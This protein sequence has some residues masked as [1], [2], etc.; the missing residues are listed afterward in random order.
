MKKI[1]EFPGVAFARSWMRQEKLAAVMV[2]VPKSAHPSLIEASAW[3]RS[4]G[5]A[6]RTATEA[7]DCF[8]FVQ[9]EVSD[10]VL[11]EAT[12]VS[13]TGTGEAIVARALVAPEAEAGEKDWRSFFDS[14]KVRFADFHL[15]A[16]AVSN[17]EADKRSGFKL[18]GSGDPAEDEKKPKLYEVA[19]SSENEIERWF[20][21]EILGHAKGEI[22]ETRV[23][24]GAAVLV[25]HYGDQVGVVEPGTFRVDDDK[26]SRAYVRFSRSQ[27]GQE[28]EQ[29][30]ADQTRQ[31]ISV[32]YFV[33]DARLVETREIGQD[34]SGRAITVDVWRVT[35]WQ[36]AE[37][38]I[39]SVPADVS[40]GVGRSAGASRGTAGVEPVAKEQIMKKKVRGDGGAIIEVDA[41]DPRP[42]IEERSVEIDAGAREREMAAITELGE[43]QGY[44]L[45]T[46]RGWLE[47]RKTVAEVQTL[48]LNAKRTTP[49][50]MPGSET[51]DG[52]SAKD[53]KRYSY[54]RAILQAA[55]A[56]EGTGKFDGVEAEF[57]EEIVGKLDPRIQRHDGIFVPMD[58]R[59]QEDRWRA[60]EARQMQT[61]TLES[62]TP[63]KG[64]E[65]IF[66]E[67]GELIEILRQTSVLARLGARILT[68]LSAPVAFPKQTGRMTA[69]WMGEN[70]ATGVTA[71][72]LGFGVVNLAPKTIQATTAFSRQWLAQ[73]GFDGE[74]IVRAE[75]GEEHALL[76]DR[77]GIHGK[78][79][80]GEPT[81]IY[82]APDAN[83]RAVGGVPDLADAI[84]SIGLVADDNALAGTLGWVTTPLMAAKL[85]QIL[86]F[87]AAGSKPIWDGS[88]SE[89]QMGGYRALSSN[90][91][92]KTM[93]GSAETGGSEHGAIFGNWRELLIG[94]FLGMEIIVDPYASKTKGLIEVTS[95]QMADV[96][97]RHGESFCKWTGATIV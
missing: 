21:L 17:A 81:G 76:W 84:D 16:R 33:N 49:V 70:P 44:D 11:E 68:G 47:S 65:L 61:R 64:G 85:R 96:V 87:S 82:L 36:P 28:I 51:I 91:V 24:R 45:K 69:F 31:N 74:G 37:V 50:A 48:I 46:V 56:R 12:I 14:E 19:V 20:G 95:F 78:G 13:L 97:L 39:V 62:K 80:A 35:R 77:S 34:S 60:L 71:S 83:A 22:D 92:S 90:Q 25:D 29:D 8:R 41:S 43:S 73:S 27:R 5:F 58:L 32:G 52:P 59:S 54:A 3:A 89:G 86:E 18:R 66:D 23:L 9:R 30:V 40:V 26:V 94:M 53:R 72:D 15:T 55:R 93:T 79:A 4:Q 6:T 57:H 63:G 42:A 75:M 10:S 2:E 88:V 1:R 38:S 67:P 7:E